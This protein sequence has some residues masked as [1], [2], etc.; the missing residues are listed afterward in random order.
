MI[1]K[2]EFYF[3]RHG[4][5]DHNIGLTADPGDIPLNTRG[6]AQACEIE[7][8]IASL[9]IKTVC[10]SPLKRAKETKE[11][12][13]ANLQAAHF[14]IAN[15]AECT[16]PIWDL[17]TAL[18]P[19]AHL[20]ADDPVRTFMQKA[21]HGINEALSQE[22]PVLIVSHGGIHWAMCCFMGVEHEWAID[23]CVPVHF[24]LGDNGKWKAKKLSCSLSSKRC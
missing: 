24:T 16:G 14:E 17:M 2:K 1:H 12:V 6:Q 22:G 13:T 5:T 7:D 23:N 8:I 21:L 11:I 3:V 20:I 10:C 9:P 18:G 15:L 19:E 4:Q